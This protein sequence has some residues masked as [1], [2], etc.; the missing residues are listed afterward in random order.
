MRT[1]TEYKP[2]TLKLQKNAVLSFERATGKKIADATSQDM[3]AWMHKLRADGMAINSC[4]AYLSVIK[5]MAAELAAAE[6]PRRA[7]TA[8]RT[9]SAEEARHLL[10]VATEKDY[11][12]LAV[13]LLAGV[14]A[15]NWTWGNLYD[16]TRI[17]PMEA[18]LV[19]VDEARRR[20]YQTFPFAYH[21]NPNA[22]WVAHYERDELVCGLTQHEINRRLKSLAR[23]DRGRKPGPADTSLVVDESSAGHWRYRSGADRV[24]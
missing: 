3:E 5:N 24:G 16:P 8:K 9:L 21:N 17:I 4:R 22:H 23:T 12:W 1:V 11:A 15:L 20:G 2:N 14:E 10:A 6:L 19:V 18:Y 7:Q 13:C